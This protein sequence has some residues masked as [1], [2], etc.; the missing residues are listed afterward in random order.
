MRPERIIRRLGVKRVEHVNGVIIGGL[1]A[2]DLALGEVTCQKLAMMMA[3]RWLVLRT[4][5]SI[6]WR[7]GSR[8]M[9][10]EAQEGK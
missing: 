1:P 4:K 10:C 9:I 8:S 3:S 5:D 2:S 7:V 6:R